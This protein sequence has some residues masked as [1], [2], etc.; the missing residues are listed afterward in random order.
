MKEKI[1]A[2]FGKILRAPVFHRKPLYLVL[3]IILSLLL[4][5]DAAMAVLIPDTAGMGNIQNMQNVQ[6]SDSDASSDDVRGDRDDD[7]DEDSV[8]DSSDEEGA[9]SSDEDGADSESVETDTGFGQ[10]DGE[11]PDMSDAENGEM[12]DM[13]DFNAE[14]GEMPDMSSSGDGQMPGRGGEAPSFDS[15]SPDGSSENV[16]DS[17]ADESEDSDTKED[18]IDSGMT[19]DGGDFADVQNN[20][21]SA[22]SRLQSIRAHWLLILIILAILDAGSI[23]MLIRISRR[24]KK[25]RLEEEKARRELAASGEIIHVE[26]PAKKESKHSHYLWIIAVIVI[27]AL[28]ILVKV[29]TRQTSASGTETEAT[30]YT[31][32]VETGS[33]DTILPGTGTLEE[34]EAEEFSLPDEVEIT[35]WYV[36]D[37][38]SVEEG[39]TLASVDPVS[40]M[41]A[42]AAVQENISSV[43]DALEDCEDDTDSETITAASA[44]RVI[45]I[46]AAE[47][48]DA[49]DTMY[50]DGALMLL[51]LDGYM[52][53]SAETDAEISTGDTVDVTLSDGT[54]VTGKVE[55]LVNQTAVI[56]LSDNGPELGDIVTVTTEDGDTVG[57]GTLYIHSELKVTGYTGTVSSISVSEGSKVSGGATLLT[58]TDTDTSAEYE[59]LL[60]QRSELESQI[61][62]LFKLY[63]DGYIYAS[64]SGVIS[65]QADTAASEDSTVSDSDTDSDSS[66][67]SASDSGLTDAASGTSSSGSAGYTVNTLSYTE[68]SAACLTVCTDQGAQAVLTT[69]T[70][71]TETGTTETDT[72]TVQ[73]GVIQS[74]SEESVTVSLLSGESST[75]TLSTVGVYKNG[76]Y[77]ASG[78]VSDIAVG[79]VLIL[80]CTG[81]TVSS[82][83]C[84]SISDT[85][86]N[87]GTASDTAENETNMADQG[88]MEGQMSEGTDSSMTEDTFSAAA[89]AEESTAS[90]TADADTAEE[91]DASAYSVSETTLL[92]ITPQD[93]MTL[94]ITVDEMDILKVEV[95]QEA[96]ITLDAFPGQSFTGTVTSID[97]SG[98]NSGGSSKYTAV[99]TMDREEDMLA[100]M[101][102]SAK[103]TLSTTENVLVIPE[104][105]LVEEDGTTLVYTTYDEDTDT[106]SDP[107]E[108]STGVSDG[109]NVEITSGLEEGDTYCYSILDVVNYSSSYS[110]SSGTGSFSI[111]SLFGGGGGGR[112]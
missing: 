63:E 44:G 111:E 69:E 4:L 57:K 98:S 52:A 31:E 101:N 16:S 95:G 36:S 9:D 66:D 15:E 26:R 32:T 40:V 64:C 109:T 94:E 22:F 103:I 85:S 13:S 68:S 100:G 77:N 51:S 38:D 56:I 87:S 88:S 21:S 112:N 1:K 54:V 91:T 30:T 29:F 76:T 20:R 19:F 11:M 74:V 86:V 2:L 41:T 7:E 59:A 18:D 37:G 72:T 97:K 104:A 46:Y 48:T 70:G 45:K 90:G 34:E 107:V 50:E 96:A 89:A 53:V 10:N 93:T 71:T 105:A 25:Q 62:T 35:K 83:T 23:F 55:S 27:V 3:T 33:I 78:T 84:I 17:T 14:D 8:S 81:D 67:D 75:V 12:P 58:L 110:S 47:D 92:S 99:I 39:D 82:A 60:E 80:T 61:A 108:V 42:I 106:L 79:D 102:A 49:A 43:D 73:I 24:Q 28:V 6:M 5:A 65:V